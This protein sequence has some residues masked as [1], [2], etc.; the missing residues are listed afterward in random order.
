MK[1]LTVNGYFFQDLG[2]MIIFSFF[3]TY[4]LL[5]LN[6]V[7]EKSFTIDI[8]FSSFKFTSLLHL[9]KAFNIFIETKQQ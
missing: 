4:I 2:N 7:I 8:I 6:S 1:H 5:I 9:L 3:I